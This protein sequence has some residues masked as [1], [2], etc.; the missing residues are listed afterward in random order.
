MHLTLQASAK[1][2]GRRK[3]V[4]KLGMKIHLKIIWFF[5]QYKY[6]DE[7]NLHNNPSDKEPIFSPVPVSTKRRIPVNCMSV[8]FG[9]EISY[10]LDFL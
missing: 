9:Q 1:L 7:H 2:P 10:S 4:L 5:L 6:D 3:D 8:L